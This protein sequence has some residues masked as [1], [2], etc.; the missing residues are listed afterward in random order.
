MLDRNKILDKEVGDHQVLPTNIYPEP[1]AKHPRSNGIGTRGKK[2]ISVQLEVDVV[3][4]FRATGRGWEKRI[5]QALR[6]W[7]GHPWI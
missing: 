7:L 4:I 1:G 5:N 2:K 3:G 6:E